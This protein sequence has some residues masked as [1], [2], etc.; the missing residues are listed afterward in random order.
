MIRPSMDHV[1]A[2]WF[3][4]CGSDKETATH[5]CRLQDHGSDN[6]RR[7]D[8]PHRKSPVRFCVQLQSNPKHAINL[9]WMSSELDALEQSNMLGRQGSD[10]SHNLTLLGLF[11]TFYLLNNVRRQA[12]LLCQHLMKRIKILL[13]LVQ[14]PGL[15]CQSS[16]S[17]RS[18][19]LLGRKPCFSVVHLFP[20]IPK[21]K[22]RVE[23]QPPCS[24]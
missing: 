1:E 19:F 10:S 3:I 21:S 4:H 17:R 7:I 20:N 18:G 2:G 8:Q 13:P 23:Q 14:L 12:H 15:N 9:S 24:L 5:G 6:E 22:R 16:F 11:T